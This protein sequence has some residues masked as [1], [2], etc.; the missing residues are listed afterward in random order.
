[1]TVSQIH[2]L[3]HPSAPSITV[4]RVIYDILNDVFLTIFSPQFINLVKDYDISIVF[5]TF[6][7]P[8]QQILFFYVL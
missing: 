4:T 5:L 8:R 1:M 2:Y 6:S 3:V 7:F